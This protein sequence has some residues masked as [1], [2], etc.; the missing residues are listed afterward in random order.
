MKRR[1]FLQIL[2]IGSAAAAAPAITK[3]KVT[4]RIVHGVWE[5]GEFT[6]SGFGLAQ[7]KAEG[8]KVAIDTGNFS[9]AIWPGLREW[10]N[11]QY[12]E[13]D[14]VNAPARSARETKE[15][16]AADVLG[17]VFDK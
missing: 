13:L 15:Q 7:V 1:T 9:G 6:P 17:R 2:G 12:D 10:Y 11:K 3:G 5:H 14:K 8:T 16:V 4:P